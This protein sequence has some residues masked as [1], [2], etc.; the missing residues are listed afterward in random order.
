MCPS[1][2]GGGCTGAAFS[3]FVTE[4]LGDR[5]VPVVLCDLPVTRVGCVSCP[6]ADVLT[7]PERWGYELLFACLL[8]HPS[9]LL[10]LPGVLFAC[11]A[12]DLPL[13]L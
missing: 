12:S 6:H 10:C 13:G 1:W 7:I 4:M 2:V 5:L 3:D 9:S 8:G 11:K